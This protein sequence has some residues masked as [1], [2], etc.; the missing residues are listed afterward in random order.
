[1]YGFTWSFLDAVLLGEGYPV[2]YMNPRGSAGYGEKFQRAVDHEWGGKAYT[3]IMQG[4]DVILA[5]NPWIDPRRLGVRGASYGGFMTNWIVSHTNRFAA[6]IP[7]ASISNFISIEGARDA[8]YDHEQ[9]FGGDLF[10]NF[11]LYWRYSPLHYAQDVKTPTLIL[12]GEADNRVPLEQA[13]EWFRALRHF[14]VPA[15]LVIFPREYHTG[16]VTGEPK[17][18]VETMRWISYWFD[19]YLNHNEA[20]A[21]PDAIG[22]SAKVK[23]AANP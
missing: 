3:D 11:D 16:M 21:P 1:M 18:V 4:V 12:H 10:Q 6:A 20:A 19:K 7:M 2:F 8:F 15:E 9:D 5:R 17:H 13:E 22:S 14:N 23:T